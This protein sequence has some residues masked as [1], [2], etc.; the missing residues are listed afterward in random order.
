MSQKDFLGEELREI[1]CMLPNR[2]AFSKEVS[3]VDVAW[4]LDHSLKVINEVIKALDASD[5]E[6]YKYEFNLSRMMVFAS[7]RIPRGRGK[8]P[9][10]ALPP[11]VIAI[12]D[13]SAQLEE[14]GSR[15]GSLVNASPNLHFD[16]PYF[17]KLNLKEAKR[18]LK[19]HTNHHLSIARDIIARKEDDE[20]QEI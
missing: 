17:G 20:N 12:E 18:F 7:G 16:H 15:L 4:H 3:K 8:A 6:A 19:I 9:K 2:D 14:A 10:V 13:L 1:E 5:P 11:K